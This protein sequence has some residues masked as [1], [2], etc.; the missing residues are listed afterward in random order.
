MIINNTFSNLSFDIFPLNNP[1]FSII[2]EYIK[3]NKTT[4]KEIEFFSDL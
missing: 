3:Q 2:Q 1:L 4:N